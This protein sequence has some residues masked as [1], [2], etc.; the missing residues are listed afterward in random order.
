[1]YIFALQSAQYD[2]PHNQTDGGSEDG[3][4]SGEKKFSF[5]KAQP[6]AP[7]PS[8]SMTPSAKELHC[9]K[10]CTKEALTPTDGGMGSLSNEAIGAVD[11]QLH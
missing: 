4:I 6:R 5:R 2:W 11:H 1:M 3:R 7:L 10:N 8:T 9:T